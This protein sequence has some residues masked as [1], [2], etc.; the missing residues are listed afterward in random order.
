MAQRVGRLAN[1]NSVI[2]RNDKIVTIFGNLWDE[3]SRLNQF[4]VFLSF[5]RS[6]N[7]WAMESGVLARC[8]TSGLCATVAGAFQKYFIYWVKVP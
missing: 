6:K 3:L 8:L 1:L 4:V 2:A 7:K 5:E